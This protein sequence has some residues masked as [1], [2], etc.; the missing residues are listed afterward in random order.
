M[1][2][3]L[4]EE[5]HTYTVAAAQAKSPRRIQAAG[6]GVRQRLQACQR[7][8]GSRYFDRVAVALACGGYAGSPASA[9][10]GSP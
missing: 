3:R 7:Q 10:V 4:W 1:R 9:A 6:V 8:Q 2:Q 5:Y